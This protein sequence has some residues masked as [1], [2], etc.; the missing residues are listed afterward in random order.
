MPPGFRDCCPTGRCRPRSKSL[1]ICFGCRPSRWCRRKQGSASL[2]PGDTDPLKA[3]NEF[4]AKPYTED[5]KRELS[6]IVEAFNE[7]HGT[8]F[9]EADMIRFEQVNREILNEDLHGNAA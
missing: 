4:G 8:E 2:S 1:T 6:E 5:E 7:R 3:I 9:T